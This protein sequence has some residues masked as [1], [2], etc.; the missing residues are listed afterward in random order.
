MGYISTGMGDR[1]GARQLSLMTLR[2]ALVDQ[3]PV[4][5]CL[6]KV[7]VFFI[8]EQLFHTVIMTTQGF[9]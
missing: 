2:L 6:F 4:Q 7:S 1:F 9:G 5:P 8:N 3:N